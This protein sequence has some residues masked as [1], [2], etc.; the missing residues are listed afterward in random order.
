MALSQI[1][2]V[3]AP[4][5]AATWRSR[6]LWQ[7]FSA[8]SGNQRPNGPDAGSNART[9]ARSHSSPAAARSHAVSGSA[10]QAAYSLP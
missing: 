6:Q 5:P 2:A 3:R 4:C 8:A 7:V 10:I 9:G 1:S